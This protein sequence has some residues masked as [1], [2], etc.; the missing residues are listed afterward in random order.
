MPRRLAQ[1]MT[2]SDPEWPFHTIKLHAI[3]VVAEIVVCTELQ[4][5]Q[6]PALTKRTKNK[7]K[8][9]L[10]VTSAARCLSM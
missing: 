4:E 1:R 9:R 2:L 8:L 5:C 6:S 3:S 7:Y 10:T